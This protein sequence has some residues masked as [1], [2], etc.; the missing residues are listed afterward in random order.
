MKVKDGQEFLAMEEFLS[1]IE[2]VFNSQ[3]PCNFEQRIIRMFLAGD[4]EF[5]NDH[6][7]IRTQLYQA[8]FLMSV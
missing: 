2:L 3:T 7:S 8:L 4:E 5:F 6:S 1:T